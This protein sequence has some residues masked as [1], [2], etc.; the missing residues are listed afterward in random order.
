MSYWVIHRDQSERKLQIDEFENDFEAQSKRNDYLTIYHDAIILDQLDIN[1]LY[2]RARK[3][4][5]K[6]VKNNK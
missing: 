2:L 5:T 4:S 6:K 1:E 3:A